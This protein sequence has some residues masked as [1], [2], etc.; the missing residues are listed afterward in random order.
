MLVEFCDA[1]ALEAVVL[2]MAESTCPAI[3]A[4]SSVMATV[5]ED[6]MGANDNATAVPE[7][8]LLETNEEDKMEDSLYEEVNATDDSTNQ[9]VLAV[10]NS[11]DGGGTAHSR[12]LMRDMKCLAPNVG[13]GCL[14]SIGYP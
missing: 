13:W 6:C 1:A 12:R 5:S 8:R 2:C 11:H 7:G 14:L 3:C 10:L 9:V 4:Q